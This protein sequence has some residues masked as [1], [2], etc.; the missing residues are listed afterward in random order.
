[1]R[2]QTPCMTQIG[3]PVTMDALGSW[4]HEVLEPEQ[5]T[6]S[7]IRYGR[8]KISRGTLILLWA[9]RV[10]VVLML[11]VISLAVWNALHVAT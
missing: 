9:L 8:R 3:E 4:V 7:K 5:L 6:A 10:Y 11:F 2:Y 1:M